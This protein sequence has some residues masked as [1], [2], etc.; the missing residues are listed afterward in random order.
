MTSRKL[1]AIVIGVLAVFAGVVEFTLAR[2]TSPSSP[3]GP[4]LA[5]VEDALANSDVG[6]AERAWQDAYGAALGARSWRGLVNVGDAAVRIGI[7]A[8]HLPPYATRA[9]EAYLAAI[10]RARAEHAVDGL[11]H[12]AA[13]FDA[14]GDRH[15]ASDCR[16]VMERLTAATPS[17]P[18]PD[19]VRDASERGVGPS[20][21]L[22]IEP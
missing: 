15:V 22:R 12:A 2:A 11:A 18:G 5:A 21:L 6:A 19:T 9:C 20:P 3:W 13:A 1:V 10:I 16:R 7:V 8:R 4:S 14:L 17:G